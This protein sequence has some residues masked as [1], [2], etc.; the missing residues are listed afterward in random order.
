MLLEA[1]EAAGDVV[2]AGRR[3]RH[4]LD[5]LA[6]APGAELQAGVIGGPIGTAAVVATT[7]DTVTVRFAPTGAAPPPL[8]IDLIVAVPRPKVLS[9]VVQV[10]AAF[11]VASIHLTRSWRVDKAYLASPRLH[12]DALALDARL[13]AEQGATTH[14]PAIVLHDRFMAM[15]DA[16]PPRPRRIVAHPIDGTP[17]ERVLAAGDPS[18][19]TIAVGPEGGWI[20]REVAT[21]VDRGYAVVAIAQPILRV[22]AAI[23]ALLG[24]LALLRRLAPVTPSR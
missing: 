21:F 2:L 20:A 15:L 10:A 4:L 5:V 18:P 11:G 13:G 19:I 1:D 7:T 8:A 24:Q 9:R 17:V 6:V 14:L 23:A 12:R 3:A 22:E 16:V